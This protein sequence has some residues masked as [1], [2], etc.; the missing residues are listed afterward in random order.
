MLNIQY[1]IKN[2][3]VRKNFKIEHSL[4]NIQ[5]SYIIVQSAEGIAQMN[6]QPS[7]YTDYNSS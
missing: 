7:V 6:L 2:F 5:H 1:R 3:E 4:L